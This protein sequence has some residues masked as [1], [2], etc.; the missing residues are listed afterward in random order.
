MGTEPSAGEREGLAPHEGENIPSP[1]T[2]TCP[3]CKT[4]FRVTEEQLGVANGRV[5]CGACLTVFD[6]SHLITRGEPGEDVPGEAEHADTATAGS[7]IVPTPARGTVA[8]AR[9]DR[10]GSP[11]PLP[12]GLFA[13]GY[14]SGAVILA[15]LVF[16]LM[17]PAWSQQPALRGI[18]Q[19]ACTVMPCE[20]PPLR[21]LN[22]ITVRPLPAERRDGPPPGLSVPLELSNQAPFRQPFPVLAVR[23][24]SADDRDLAEKRLAPKDYLPRGHSLKMTPNDPVTVEL[25]L[26]DP[27][28]DAARYML[29]A[30]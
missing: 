24:L 10:A 11:T 16:G 18:Y 19:A 9:R 17:Y 25:Q 30:L 8:R 28:S 4:R 22:A 1:L 27:G 5:R 7:A 2:C 12:L 20:L 3:G 13:T 23:I 15:A 29:S 21:A 14:A 26:E 6:C